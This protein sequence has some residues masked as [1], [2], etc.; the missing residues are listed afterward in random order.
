VKFKSNKKIINKT[1]L[2]L[3]PIVVTD[4]IILVIQVLVKKFYQ[5]LELL[6]KSS[7]AKDLEIVRNL[8]RRQKSY[9]CVFI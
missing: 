5:M 9:V 6:C 1:K 8:C 3:F 4:I 7:C 2:N